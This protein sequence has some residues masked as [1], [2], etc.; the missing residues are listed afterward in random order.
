MAIAFAEGRGI[1]GLRDR[2][3]ETGHSDFT[4]LAATRTDMWEVATRYEAVIGEGEL[5]GYAMTKP[6]GSLLFFM[7][8]QEVSAWFGPAETVQD[9][10]RTLVTFAGYVYPLICYLALFPLFWLSRRLLGEQSALWPCV[11]YVFLPNVVLMTLHLDQ[12]WYPTLFLLL[13]SLAIASHDKQSGSLSLLAGV[14]VYLAMFFSFSLLAA[15]GLLAVFIVLRELHGDRKLPATAIG[16]RWFVSFLAGLAGSWA[17]G[18]LVLNYDPVERF[19]NAME[20]H[21]GFKGWEGGFGPTVY[22]AG[23]NW[24]EYASWIGWPVVLLFLGH[25]WSA[26]RETVRNRARPVDTLGVAAGCTLL[27]LGL[28]GRTQ[29]EVARLWLFL[30]G[31]VCIG[32]CCTI[33][34]RFGPRFKRLLTVI[35]AVQWVTILLIKRFQDFW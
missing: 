27:F 9:R 18:R 24:L 21:Q 25:L 16:L 26:T 6:P 33:A 12:V 23:S 10:F 8:S 5:A 11:L 4:V 20:Q 30:G 31:V 34:D 2:L 29:G 32:A 15:C 1:D 3:V 22:W 28:F 35:V 17:L 19:R 13:T 14:A 7:A